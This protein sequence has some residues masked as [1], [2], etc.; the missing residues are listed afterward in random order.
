MNR[1]YERTFECSYPGLIVQLILGIAAVL[2]NFL[3]LLAFYKNSAILEKGNNLTLACLAVGDFIQGCGA[4]IYDA[5]E[6]RLKSSDDLWPAWV[7][8]Y[9]GHF[10]LEIGMSA[11]I[12]WLFMVALQRF[13]AVTYPLFTMTNLTSKRFALCGMTVYA[14]F[15]GGL[16]VVGFH[17]NELQ[18]LTRTCDLPVV[19]GV[20]YLRCKTA[21]G[22]TVTTLLYISYVGVL[23]SVHRGTHQLV[24]LQRQEGPGAMRHVRR[25]SVSSENRMHKTLT[26]LLLAF[27]VFYTIP[28]CMTFATGFVEPLHFTRY[29][30]LSILPIGIAC[31]SM[32][33][34]FIYLSRNN[35]LRVCILDLL[36]RAVGRT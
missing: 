17:I 1:T 19:F 23:I 2:T 6:L 3:I 35:E 4:I 29:A 16:L 31:N 24:E 20:T 30:V 14:L 10:V 25:N 22:L 28:V 26:A 5:V 34:I 15:F 7:C 36:S 18:T 33:N 9:G 21:A 27:T 13:I 11:S 12:Y 8:I 32:I